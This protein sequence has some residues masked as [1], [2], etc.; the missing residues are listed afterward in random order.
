MRR[1]IQSALEDRLSD[2]VLSGRFSEGDIIDA[3]AV[4]DEIVMNIAEIEPGDEV[5]EGAE[6]PLPAA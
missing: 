6:E 4:D 5:A 2:A 1:L 3:D